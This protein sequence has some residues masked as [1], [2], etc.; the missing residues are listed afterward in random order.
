MLSDIEIAQQATLAPIEEIA[1][2][3]GL[4]E[5][6]YTPWGSYKAKVELSVL[7]RISAREP[8][9]LIL[10]TTTSPTPAGEGKTTMTIGL[11]QALYKLEHR[12]MIGIREPSM[13][14]VF[15]IKGGAAGGG[16]SQVLPMEDINLHF[17]GDIHAIT[18]AHNLLAALLNNHM[19]HGNELNIDPR[20]I[21]WHRVMDMNDRALRNTVIGLGGSASGMPQEDSFDIT[22]ASEVMAILCISTSIKDLKERLSR[23]IVAYKM[24]GEPVHAKDLDAV[25]AMALLLRDAIRPNLVQT[26]EGVPAFI[27]GGPFANIAHGTS[28]YLSAKIGLHLCDYFITEAGFGSDLGAE[29]FFDIFCRIT[30]LMPSAVVMVVTTRS[31]KMQGGVPKDRIKEADVLSV[32]RGMGNLN[33]HLQIVHLFGLPVVVA[34]NH[35]E[36]DHDDEVQEILRTCEAMGIPIAVSDHHAKGG[37]GAIE[38]AKKLVDVVKGCKQCF[39]TLYPDNLPLKEKIKSICHN[40]YGANKVVFSVDATKKMQQYEEMG[41]GGLPICMAKTQ[42]SLSDD[43]K[44]LGAPTKFKITISDIRL[45]A[46]AGFLIPLTGNINTMPGLPKEPAAS[47]MDVTDEGKAIGLF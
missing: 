40:V 17:T 9:H 5:G 2:K 46:G 13:G 32:R 24:T 26:I 29:K 33:R 22:A 38:V 16:Y 4:K 36:D 20:R 34:I 25:G 44:L 41:Y 47:R 11:A 1:E 8:G 42:Y 31:L 37:D 10:V 7:D 18:A 15:G 35:F 45:S 39:N 28:S 3:A 43:P 23:I 21:V 14:P 27:H 6:E 30:G 19:H 12:T